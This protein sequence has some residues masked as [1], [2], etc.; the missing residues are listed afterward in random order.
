MNTIWSDFA[1]MIYNVEVEVGRRAGRP[2]ASLQAARQRQPAVQAA[3]DPAARSTRRRPPTAHV[4]E[5]ARRERGDRRRRQAPRR[6]A[7]QLDGTTR[8]GARV[9]DATKVTC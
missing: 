2:P 4:V 9:H 8:A 5:G 6:P 3:L 1:R 7:A